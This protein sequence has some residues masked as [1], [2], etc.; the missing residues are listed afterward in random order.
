MQLLC[1]RKCL[2][3]TAKIEKV[4]LCSQDGTTSE[5]TEGDGTIKMTEHKLNLAADH[6]DCTQNWVCGT[7]RTNEHT[8]TLIHTHSLARPHA[9]T[10]GLEI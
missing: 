9:G 5:L 10:C 4:S 1:E 7:S 8:H 3:A 6:M 2:E